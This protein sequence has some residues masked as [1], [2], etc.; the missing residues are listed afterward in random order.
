[1]VAVRLILGDCLDILPTLEAGSVDAVATD[2]PYGMRFM[3]MAWD[4][5]DITQASQQAATR[6]SKRQSQMTYDKERG[7]VRDRGQYGYGSPAQKAGEY[8]QSCE[9]HLAFQAWCTEWATAA[10]RVLKPGGY[11]LS[12]GGT[13]TFHRLACALE[14]AG[15]EMRDT[16]CWLYGSGFPKGKG[17]L[18]PAW[19][20]VLLC[21][22]P[23]PKMLALGIDCCRVNVGDEVTA[24]PPLS[25]NKHEGYR[26]P[27][28][29]NE[30]ARNGVEQR[31]EE[32]HDKRDALGRW[33]ANVVHDGSDEVLEAFA[34]AGERNGGARPARRG[35]GTNGYHG[36][37]NG[38]NDGE[39][40]ESDS[41]T[42]A[43]FFYCAKSSKR[44]RGSGN[45]HPTVKPLALMR[46]LV[47]L[48]TPPGGVC[49]DPFLGSGTTGLACALE[50]FGFVGIER[51]AEYLK[52]AQHRIAEVDKDV[53]LF[54]Q[55]A[56]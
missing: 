32:A 50:G 41:G 8:D 27:W 42:A 7:K 44:E 17:C 10:L 15:F 52:I 49:L 18:K 13:R 4:G 43:R 22:K 3:G 30:E 11:L 6:R 26:R 36:W 55:E 47:R 38:T 12:F 19:E 37:P 39:R 28:N 45:L 53:P 1:M 48:V 31:R 24:R 2:P 25:T 9:G 56:V 16:L 29:E 54:A 34:V 20:P 14:D 51:K 5:A 21:R 40:I 23:G 35:A 33:P 46:W